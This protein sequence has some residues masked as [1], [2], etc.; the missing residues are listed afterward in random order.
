[1]SEAGTLTDVEGE[2]VDVGAGNVPHGIHAL[3]ATIDPAL[4]SPC[5]LTIPRLKQLSQRRNIKVAWKKNLQQLRASPIL[6]H[7]PIVVGRVGGS[8]CTIAFLSCADLHKSRMIHHKRRLSPNL[9]WEHLRQPRG[10]SGTLGESK[11]RSMQTSPSAW[12]HKHMAC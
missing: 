8:I 4:H 7:A 5:Q 11:D 10:V 9:L 3:E 12:T 6:F 2:E 1:M